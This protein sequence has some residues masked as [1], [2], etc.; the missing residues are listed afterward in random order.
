MN[1]NSPRR[2]DAAIRIAENAQAVP[3]EPDQFTR[4]SPE[5]V[6]TLPDDIRRHNISDE[7]LDLLCESRSDYAL[8]IVLLAGGGAIGSAPAAMSAVFAYLKSTEEAPAKISTV[9]FSQMMLFFACCA[10]AI[11]VGLIFK[12]RSNRAIDLRDKIRAR[13]NHSR[14]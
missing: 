12:A 2:H 3:T 7:D 1:E 13:S 8:E 5:I 11:C 14:G 10:V 4:K 9:D 6:T